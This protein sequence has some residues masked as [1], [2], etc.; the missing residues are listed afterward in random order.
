MTSF[1]TNNLLLLENLFVHLT[2]RQ[3]PVIFYKLLG[4][5]ENEI[6]RDLSITQTAVNLRS[7]NAGWTGIKDT[8]KVLEQIDFDRY[9][10]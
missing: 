8:L 10:V 6:A 1:I 4:L 7:R 9:V 2:E 5:T 3:C